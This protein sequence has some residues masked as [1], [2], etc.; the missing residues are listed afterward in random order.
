MTRKIEYILET[1]P[2]SRRRWYHNLEAV[3]LVVYM[4]FLLYALFGLIR[5]CFDG[6]TEYL[7]AIVILSLILGIVCLYVKFVDYG[8]TTKDKKRN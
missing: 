6:A 4:V 2:K 5:D 1:K 7:S 3:L 8:N